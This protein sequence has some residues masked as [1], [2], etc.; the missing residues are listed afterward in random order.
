[1]EEL[2]NLHGKDAFQY[3][4]FMWIGI[5][6]PPLFPCLPWGIHAREKSDGGQRAKARTPSNSTSRASR[7]QESSDGTDNGQET[8]TSLGSS[9][10]ELGGSGLGAG[11]RGSSGVGN[12]AVASRW[13]RDVGRGSGNGSLA[14]RRSVVGHDGRDS[15][16]RGHGRG[17]VGRS[18][19]R[20]V[21]SHRG[22]SLVGGLSR[23]WGGLGRVGGRVLAVLV[24][25]GGAGL[26]DV[27]LGAVG[28]CGGLRADGGET[29]DDLGGVDRVLGGHGGDGVNWVV[30]NGGGAGGNRVLGR[31]GG[32]GRSH[33]G[34]V[35]LSMVAVAIGVG[36]NG[37]AGD[38]SEGAHVD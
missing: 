23:S 3:T 25:D 28:D 5:N 6:N 16:S 12:G 29:S 15:R 33:G 18:H 9:T 17:G 24:D 21:R 2:V 8:D 7:L 14:G 35:D 38:D 11:R 20:L 32:S 26:D 36:S 10:G 34:V 22:R 13:V 27:G 31:L 19:R 4:T 37:K 30:L 1:M